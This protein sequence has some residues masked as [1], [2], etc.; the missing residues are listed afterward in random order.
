MQD[1]AAIVQDTTV[2]GIYLQGKVYLMDRRRMIAA[3]MKNDTEQ[4]QAV[5]VIG[6]RFQ[7]LSINRLGFWQSTGLMKRERL[8]ER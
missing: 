1:K 6:L 7:D 5:K 4:V 3:L 8:A 2:I